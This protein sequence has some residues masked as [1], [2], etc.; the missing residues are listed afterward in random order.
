[1]THIYCDFER[2]STNLNAKHTSLG[3]MAL[4][5]YFV[6]NY[7]EKH[8]LTPVVKSEVN[9]SNLFNFKDSVIQKDK[10]IDNLKC[11]FSEIDE[12][13]RPSK[14]R[15]VLIRLTGKFLINQ[16]L[17]DLHT[18]SYNSF[19]ASQ[20]FLEELNTD[21]SNKF[22][23]GH[24]W[25]YDLMP[26]IE[27][28]NKYLTVNEKLK[29]KVVRDYDLITDKN[30]IAVHFRGGDF[31]LPID[32]LHI[33]KK[34]IVLPKQYYENAID[35]VYKKIKDPIFHLFSDEMSTLKKYFEGHNYII[36]DGNAYEDWIAISICYNSIQS[37]S[38]FSWTASLFTQGLLI[39]P[40]N[41]LAYNSEYGSYPYGFKHRE[42]ICI[43]KNFR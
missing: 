8:K 2:L 43:E 32:G 24:F 26:S 13:K 7:A 29:S 38:S 23:K 20:N 22:I 10:N 18:K 35:E 28:V 41:G 16:T 19:L 11:A 42:S 27:I 9:I 15:R 1:M 3:N 12:M 30:S 33:Y 25:H 36:H 31:R 4:H 5:V 40:E 39:Q 34:G 37:N 6:I 17:L 14:M 21:H